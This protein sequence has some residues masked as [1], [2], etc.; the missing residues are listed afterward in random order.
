MKTFLLLPLL[1]LASCNKQEINI[2]NKSY[3]SLTPEQIIF[4]KAPKKIAQ[5][6]S[7]FIRPIV[8]VA[9]YLDMD[10]FLI[11]SVAWTETHFRIRI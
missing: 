10:P 3:V 6:S 11:Y 5:K 9:K 8:K 4:Q 1:V 7:P 2:S